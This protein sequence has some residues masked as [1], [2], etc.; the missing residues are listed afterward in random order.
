MP[1]VGRTHH[2]RRFFAAMP[3]TSVLSLDTITPT[4]MPAKTKKIASTTT[5][6]TAISGGKIGRKSGANA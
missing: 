2:Q 5:R 4:A 6:I 3:E 1:F